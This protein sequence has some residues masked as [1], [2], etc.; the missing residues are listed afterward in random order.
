[1]AVQ[2]NRKSRSRRGMRRSHDRLRPLMPVVDADTG[3]SHLRHRV[4]PDGWYRGA[5]GHRTHT[6]ERGA[7]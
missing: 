3:E 7:G 5:A 4:S 6:R 2:Q 1:M